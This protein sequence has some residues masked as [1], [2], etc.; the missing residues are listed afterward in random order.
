MTLYGQVGKLYHEAIAENDPA[1]IDQASETW[2]QGDAQWQDVID[3]I[4]ISDDAC[5]V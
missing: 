1:K 2:K 5:G 3:S 4:P